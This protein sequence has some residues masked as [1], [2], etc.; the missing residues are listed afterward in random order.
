MIHIKEFVNSV[1]TSKTYI[2]Y[3]EGEKWVW[4]VDIGDVAPVVSF[5][6]D[7]GMIVKGVFLTHAHF[8]HIYGL[9]ALIEQYPDGKVYCTEYS[10]MALAS[11]KLNM[12]RYHE[13]PIRYER[14]NVEVVQEGDKMTLYNGESDIQFYETPGHNPGC[15]TLVLG[16]YIFTGDAYIPGVKV[17]TNLP[18]GDKA[19]AELSLERI[20]K[21]TEGKI[22]L[23]GHQVLE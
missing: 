9:E 1:F 4:L 10:K 13:R 15:L 3:R 16:D 12:S 5:L 22:V 18:K 21:L 6:K 17:V 7:K 14:N 20:I 2:L 19:L 23:P 11:D 8:D